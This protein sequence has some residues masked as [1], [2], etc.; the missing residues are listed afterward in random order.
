MR[1]WTLRVDDIADPVPGRGQ[2]LTKVSRAGSAAVTC[3]CSATVRRA[4]V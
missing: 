3:T 4:G 2:V 1:D